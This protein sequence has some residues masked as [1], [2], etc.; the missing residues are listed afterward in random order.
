MLGLAAVALLLLLPM[1]YLIGVALDSQA[2]AFVLGGGNLLLVFAT[3]VLGLALGIHARKSGAWALVGI[4]TSV[5]ALV[6]SLIV[7]AVVILL[8]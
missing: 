5:L 3:G 4:V 1:S 7:V 8:A 6:L 2:L